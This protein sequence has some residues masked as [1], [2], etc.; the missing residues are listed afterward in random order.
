M[1]HFV[2]RAAAIVRE[3]VTLFLMAD[4][5]QLVNAVRDADRYGSAPAGLSV[6]APFGFVDQPSAPVDDESQRTASQSWPQVSHNVPEY[7]SGHI[8]VAGT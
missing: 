1:Q 6:D 7:V 2:T 3:N 4:S 8:I 5:K